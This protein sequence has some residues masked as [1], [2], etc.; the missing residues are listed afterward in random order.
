VSLL[1]S[2]LILK[3]VIS[4]RKPWLITR[5]EAI[6]IHTPYSPFENYSIIIRVDVLT[7]A[8][9]CLLLDFREEGIDGLLGRLR[10][11]H[12]RIQ[13]NA[14]EIL[15]ILFEQHCFATEK[16]RQ[17]A[18]DRIVSM[19]R[20]TGMT[21]LIGAYGGKHDQV[22]HE[23]LIK[24]LHACN[25]DLIFLDNSLQFEAEM[26]RFC[27]ETV[28]KFED[29]NT[30]QCGKALSAP[31]RDAIFQRIDYYLDSSRWRRTQA[32]SLMK[33]V[34]TQ[35]NVVSNAYQRISYFAELTRI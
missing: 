23:K 26:G 10:I 1:R 13:K 2:C 6:I 21:S 14:L 17:Q 4:E 30:T 29:L 20:K 32:L 24:D 35:I 19:E 3:V 33:R 12:E 16:A 27:R 9:T 28:A 18:D 15:A 25:T 5:S 11:R 8:A 31:D 34:K 22:D 7:R